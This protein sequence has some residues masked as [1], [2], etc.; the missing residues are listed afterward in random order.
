MKTSVFLAVCSLI[1]MLI[2]ADAGI[3]WLAAIWG[4]SLGLHSGYILKSIA[5]KRGSTK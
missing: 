5:E 4:V 1:F 3:S 2:Y